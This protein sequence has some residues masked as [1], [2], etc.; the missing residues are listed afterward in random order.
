MESTAV[1]AAVDAI[2]GV[3]VS[4][5]IGDIDAIVSDIVTNHNAHNN[6]AG[7]IHND[8]DT[9]NQIP[10]FYAST[11]APKD[12][13]TFVNVAL[14]YQRRHRTNDDG[15]GTPGA[16][17]YHDPTGSSAKA[18]F[19]NIPIID[20]VAGLAEAYAALAEIWRCHEGH[21][22]TPSE[23]HGTPSAPV[24]SFALATLPPILQVHLRVF[25]VLASFSSAAVP[26]QIP[27]AQLLIEQCGGVE[28]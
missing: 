14:Q 8:A 25:E 16:G 5:A 2:A 27:G 22:V 1:I 19:A 21:R 13:P 10:V 24:S 20:Q 28:G 12:L 4:S 9:D 15:S 11:M 6:I 7:G 18:D 26:T 17:E 3:T 23:W